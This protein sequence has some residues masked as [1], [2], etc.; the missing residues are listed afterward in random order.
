MTPLPPPPPIEDF[1]RIAQPTSGVARRW[2]LGVAAADAVVFPSRYS[3]RLFDAEVVLAD[4]TRRIASPN[5][6]NASWASSLRSDP[7]AATSDLITIGRLSREKYQVF[8]LHIVAALR[9]AGRDT[10]LSVVGAGPELGAL[11]REA[12]ALG[13]DDLVDFVG[14]STDVRTLLLQHR[15]YIHTSVIETFGITIIEAMAL[16]MPSLVAPQGALAELVHDG[17]EGRHLDL[18]SLSRSRDVVGEVIDDTVALMRMGRQ[19]RARFE[20]DFEADAVVGP[21][22]DA[23]GR[24]LES[25]R[26]EAR[27]VHASQH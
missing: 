14:A 12:A 10:T 23:L 11:R 16:G 21:L 6:L 26:A 22:E 15:A 18:G 4:T 1:E 20:R 3:E 17:V 2:R 9:D 25:R 13:I 27:P 5:F 7:C 24:L 8:G 19:A